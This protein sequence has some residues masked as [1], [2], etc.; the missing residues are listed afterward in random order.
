MIQTQGKINHTGLSWDFAN[1]TFN[2][3]PNAEN[4]KKHWDQL[5]ARFHSQDVGFYLAPENSEIS[6]INEVLTFS[7]KVLTENKFE[8]CLFLGIGGSALGPKSLL[9]ALAHKTSSKIQFHFIENPDANDWHLKTKDLPKN[10][11]LVCAVSKS[12]GTLETIA[13]FLAALEW[14]GPDKWKEQTVILTDPNNGDLFN[15]AKQN[16]IETLSIHPSIGGRFSIF[17]PVGLLPLALKGLDPNEFLL[18]AK[19]LVEFTKQTPLEEHPLFFL[20]HQLLQNFDSFST[21]VLM[22]YSTQLKYFSDWF[23]QLWGESLGKNRKGFTPLSATGAIDQHSILQLLRDGP[24]DKVTF[25][26]KTKTSK[27]D[28]N[29]KS[30]G[31]QFSSFKLLQG[32]SMHTLLNLE[33]Q[34][35]ALVLKRN[36]RPNITFELESLET[37]T[38]GATYFMFCLLTAITG[39]LW[40]VNPFDQP[41]VEEGKIYLKK[42]LEK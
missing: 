29:L 33:H 22:P 18:G 14:I 28:L 41:G 19:K 32:Q 8:H 10:K 23:V 35:T 37:K 20:S 5:K 12:G 7:K 21:H 15:F 27:N 11:T 2:Q 3:N 26:I 13:L 4:L 16:Q 30:D 36:Q 1:L 42:A 24:N 9:Q 25:F 17:S 34:S 6:Q 39:A 31:L 40:E 38:L